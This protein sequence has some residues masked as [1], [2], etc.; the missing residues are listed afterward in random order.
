MLSKLACGSVGPC[1][2]TVS[3]TDVNDRRSVVEALCVYAGWRCSG[4]VGSVTRVWWRLDTSERVERIIENKRCGGDLTP[5]SAWRELLKTSDFPNSF[6][7]AYFTVFFFICV[8]FLCRR[9]RHFKFAHDS[10]SAWTSTRTNLSQ[11]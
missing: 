9:L 1:R 4:A 3:D 2:C 8:F 7:L 11:T 10:E 5:V 6:P